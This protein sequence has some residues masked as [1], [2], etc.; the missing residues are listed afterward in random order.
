MLWQYGHTA[1]G[2]V[3]VRFPQG[4][5]APNDQEEMLYQGAKFVQTV[6]VQLLYWLTATVR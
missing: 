6:V 5:Y 2:S 1:V 4:G 3:N